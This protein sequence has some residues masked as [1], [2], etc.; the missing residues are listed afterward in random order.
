MACR[1]PGCRIK[2]GKIIRDS[3]KV[4]RHEFMAFSGIAVPEKDTHVR[5]KFR[6]KIFKADVILIMGLP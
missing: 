3:V 1:P 4:E 6:L 2:L 5:R